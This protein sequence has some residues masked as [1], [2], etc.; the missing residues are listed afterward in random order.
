MKKRWLLFIIYGLS[1]IFIW[2]KYHEKKIEPWY[3]AFNVDEI[4]FI[5]KNGIVQLTIPMEDITQNYK[6]TNPGSEPSVDHV[7]HAFSDLMFQMS[8]LKNEFKHDYID[9]IKKDDLWFGFI[10][11]KEHVYVKPEYYS[12]SPFEDG[13]TIVHTKDG[14]QGVLNEKGEW[15]I[16]PDYDLIFEYANDS[17]SV[18]KDGKAGIINRKGKVIGGMKFTQTYPFHDDVALVRLDD[19]YGYL[20]ESGSWHIEPMF[21]DAS[22]FSEGLAAVKKDDLFGYIDKN[23]KEVI[24]YQFQEAKPFKNGL[25]IVRKDS[26]VGLINEDGTFII[27]PTFTDIQPIENDLYLVYV[28]SLVG[29]YNHNGAELIRPENLDILPLSHSDELYIVTNQNQKQS[30]FHIEKGVISKE[31]DYIEFQ[32]NEGLILVR[33]RQNDSNMDETYHFNEISGYLNEEG[34]EVIPLKYNMAQSFSNGVAIAQEIESGLIGGIDKKGNWVIKP[35]YHYISSFLNGFAYAFIFNGEKEKSYIIDKT[36]R[37]IYES[38]DDKIIR[39]FHSYNF[40]PTA[41]E[42]D[43][44]L[45]TFEYEREKSKNLMRFAYVDDEGNIVWVSEEFV[46]N[47]EEVF[48]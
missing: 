23:G 19:K 47:I 26:K 2:K 18:V 41:N 32:M 16:K 37:I 46:Y 1:L 11:R 42:M 25:A 45:I 43:L 5:N 7:L 35:K 9:I 24:G 20:N 40:L 44:T 39:L 31:Y 21:N 6:N 33:N 10:N 17:F 38:Q 3:P 27:E 34:K 22:S 28:N 8:I 4:Q 13:M 48:D 30:L 14:G 12:M 29:L 15:V 36:G